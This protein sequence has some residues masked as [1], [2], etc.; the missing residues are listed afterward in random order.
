MILIIWTIRSAS[1]E[2]L[3]QD[4]ISPRNPWKQL[5][6]IGSSEI[7]RETI[8]QSLEILILKAAVFL[9]GDVIYTS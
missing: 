2:M 9:L 5:T 6:C 7:P 4:E 3:L 8:F 1:Q